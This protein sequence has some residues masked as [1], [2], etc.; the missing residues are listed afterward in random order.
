MYMWRGILAT[1]RKL[2]QQQN[3]LAVSIILTIFINLMQQSIATKFNTVA[4]L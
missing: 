4:I 1:A 2:T 3:L